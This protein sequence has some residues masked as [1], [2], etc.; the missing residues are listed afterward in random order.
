MNLFSCI[1]GYNTGTHSLWGILLSEWWARVEIEV[2]VYTWGPSEQYTHL[3]VILPSGQL[4]INNLTLQS[5][6]PIRISIKFV[7]WIWIRTQ[8]PDQDHPCRIRIQFLIGSELKLDDSLTLDVET[9]SSWPSSD[10]SMFSRPRSSSSVSTWLV[11]FRSVSSWIFTVLSPHEAAFP[12]VQCLYMCQWHV[13]CALYPLGSP[14]NENF[15]ETKSRKQ[16]IILP[17]CCQNRQTKQNPQSWV[18]V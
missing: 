14:P 7:S 13:S 8:K 17:K 12:V 10:Q 5:V 1:F 16:R 2:P 4:K 15:A 18:K 11:S 6:F 3:N 9:A